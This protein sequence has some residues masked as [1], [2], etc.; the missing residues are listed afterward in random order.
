[1]A[2]PT[3]TV[4]PSFTGTLRVGRTLTGS[5]GTW[6]G[7][8]T[9]AYQW[10]R[11]EVITLDGFPIT[12]N[13]EILTLAFADISL[14]TLITH[15]LAHATL[16][17]MVRLKVTGTNGDGSAIAYSAQQGPV[18]GAAGGA[19]GTLGGALQ[20]ALIGTLGFVE[21]DEGDER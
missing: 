3:N 17:Y 5:D 14:A 19:G 6:T 2:V 9:F 16:T 1:M 12:V 15:L 13:G 20:A 18:L 10:Q 11:A 21:D 8:P 4:A 7:S